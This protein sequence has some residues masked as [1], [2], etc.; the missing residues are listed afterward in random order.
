[1]DKK[2]EITCK[3]LLMGIVKE[4]KKL[5]FTEKVKLFTVIKEMKH[6]DVVSV[7]LGEE[8][9]SQPGKV[10]KT[11]L[12]A[13]A[14]VGAIAANKISKNSLKNLS[15]K[16]SIIGAVSAAFLYAMYRKLS[17]PCIRKN[18]GNKVKQTECRIAGIKVVI[19]KLRAEL[20][21]CNATNNPEKCKAKINKE[22][23]KW[24]TILRKQ[25]VNH[26]KY[27]RK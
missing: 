18:L 13:A 7:L 8:N 20:S 23:V 12:A 27:L 1:M 19:G 22:V 17:D 2:F 6:I 9:Y 11:K 14:T 15:K 10:S 25:L 24:E 5:S 4:S 3:K 16:K 26:S 21:K